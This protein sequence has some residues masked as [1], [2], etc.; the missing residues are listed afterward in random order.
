MRTCEVCGLEYHSSTAETLS[1]K[2]GYCGRRACPD[3]QRN[4]KASNGNLVGTYCIECVPKI[5]EEFRSVGE[6]APEF[7]QVWWGKRDSMDRP[8]LREEAELLG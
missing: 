8:I 6:D 7:V 4:M 2:C 5:Q 3:C 1:A